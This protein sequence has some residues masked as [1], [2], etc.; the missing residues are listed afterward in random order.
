VGSDRKT[1]GTGTTS[2]LIRRAATHPFR[3]SRDH[4]RAARRLARDSWQRRPP[5]RRA[6]AILF[7]LAGVAAGVTSTAWQ[8]SLRARLPSP[9]D[10]DALRAL[11][12]RDARPGDALVP[13]PAWAERVRLLAPPAAPVASYEGGTAEDLPGVRRVWLAAL[14]ALPRFSWGTELGLLARSSGSEPTLALGALEVT[15]FQLAAP[16]LPMAF[17]PDLLGQAEVKLGDQPCLPEQEGVL[18]CADGG[19]VA[20]SVREVGG[21]PRPC[22]VVHPD[23]AAGAPLA[24]TFRGVPLGRAFHGHA[25]VAGDPGATAPVRLSVHV[26]DEEAGEVELASPGWQAFD[27]DT[28]RFAGHA[29]DVTLVLTSAAR[30]GPLCLDAVTVP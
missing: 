26:D 18:R 21:R 15:R 30:P 29:R 2:D 24:L 17:L 27:V 19:E 9:L 14:P 7:A 16:Q 13:A 20:R 22:L 10:W 1:P 28:A 25:G 12:E 4:L 5:A 6:V 3:A 8:S 23:A 11:L